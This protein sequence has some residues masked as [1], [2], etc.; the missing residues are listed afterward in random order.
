MQN[1]I[2][3]TCGGG[4]L[5][6]FDRATGSPKFI[7]DIIAST[8]ANYN[9]TS[10]HAHAGSASISAEYCKLCS[11]T[12]SISLTETGSDYLGTYSYFEGLQAVSP[13]ESQKHF[14]WSWNGTLSGS[15]NTNM[16]KLADVNTAIQTAD[17]DF[18]SWLQSVGGDVNDA[19]GNARGTETW[20]GAYQGTSLTE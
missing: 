19:L 15:S 13:S 11:F 5:F 6:R 18:Y 4:A 3:T 17:A 16:A 7:N 8:S 20:P 10:I 14:Y 9:C 2:P 12:I 1:N